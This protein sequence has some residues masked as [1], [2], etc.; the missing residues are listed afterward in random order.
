MSFSCLT[1][2]ELVAGFL[3]PAYVDA[4][5]LTIVSKPTEHNCGTTGLILIVE[6]YQLSVSVDKI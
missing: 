1:G 4:A 5:K 6:R 3:L 2:H